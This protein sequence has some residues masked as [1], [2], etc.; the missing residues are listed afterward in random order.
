VKGNSEEAGPFPVGGIHRKLLL[1]E[2]TDDNFL[3]IE[4]YAIFRVL[5]IYYLI[6]L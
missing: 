3:Y 4:L 1:G 5:S 2:K 6:A